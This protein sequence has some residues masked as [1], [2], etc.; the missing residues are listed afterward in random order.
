MGCPSGIKPESI[1][2]NRVG[3]ADV[4]NALAGGV[5]VVEIG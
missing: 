1:F 5:V 4:F 2:H 3:Y